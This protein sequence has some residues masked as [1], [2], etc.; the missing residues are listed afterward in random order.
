M[1]EIRTVITP[2]TG[3]I[4]QVE[5]YTHDEFMDRK[6]AKLEELRAKAEE[7]GKV[8]VNGLT[9]FNLPKHML[10]CVSLYTEYKRV[11]ASVGPMAVGKG[12]KP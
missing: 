8:D 10:E 7:M 2:S 11:L 4:E 5:F 6:R 3:K 1:T 12:T 9:L